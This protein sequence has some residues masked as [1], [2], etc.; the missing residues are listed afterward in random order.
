MKRPPPIRPKSSEAAKPSNPGVIDLTD[1]DDRST[2]PPSAQPVKVLG[3]QSVNSP[4]L[5][6]TK[7]MGKSPNNQNK[8]VLNQVKPGQVVSKG[9]SKGRVLTF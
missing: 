1:E 6:A 9:E 5:V 8:M 7:V 4:K 2:K 3:K